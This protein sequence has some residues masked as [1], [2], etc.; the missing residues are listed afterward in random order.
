MKIVS[1]DEFKKLIEDNPGKKFAFVE[2]EPRVANS[3]L[4]ITDG[5]G[6]NRPHLGLCPGLNVHP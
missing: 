2:W 3:E 5:A 6:Q 4:H 1:R